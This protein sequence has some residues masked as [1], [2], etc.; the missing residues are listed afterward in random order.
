MTDDEKDEMIFEVLKLHVGEFKKFFSN[1]ENPRKDRE[2]ALNDIFKKIN[3]VDIT[4][5]QNVELAKDVFSVVDKMPYLIEFD[6]LSVFHKK[7]GE[8]LYEEFLK[9]TQ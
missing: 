5:E 1:A 9:E 7:H 4:F 3:R 8:R 6:Q 2:I